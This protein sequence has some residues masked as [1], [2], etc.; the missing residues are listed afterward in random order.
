MGRVGSLAAQGHG[1]GQTREADASGVE[2]VQESGS[3]IAGE[4]FRLR[5][6][7]PEKAGQVG[8]ASGW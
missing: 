3:P 5:G 2:V 4:G 6:P 7:S 1:I 8:K